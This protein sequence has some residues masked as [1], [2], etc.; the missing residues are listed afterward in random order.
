MRSIGKYPALNLSPKEFELF[1]KRALDATGMGLPDYQSEHRETLTAKDGE[2]EID[3]VVRFTAL[4]G[5]S[6]LTLVE[7]KNWRNS[8]KR[9]T[10]QE[11]LR[12]I[13]S[14]GAHK[15]IIFTT[16]EYQPGAVK[17][18]QA[19]HIGLVIVADGHS[20]WIVKDD[21]KHAER[22]ELEDVRDYISRVVGWLIGER[23][24]EIR[25]VS[26]THGQYLKDTIIGPPSR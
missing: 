21:E 12:K 9:A 13:R 2:Y 15:G 16:S 25:L 8:V 5:A 11:L 26:K 6:F 19:H 7:C 22:T 3:I 23:E 18:A 4:G 17:F 10:V 1:V 14:T 24:D 20:E